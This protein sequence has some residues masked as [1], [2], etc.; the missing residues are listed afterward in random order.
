MINFY[1]IS[2]HILLD[3]LFKGLFWK[4]KCICIISVV[5]IL[6]FRKQVLNKQWQIGTHCYCVVAVYLVA[7]NI[8]SVKMVVLESRITGGEQTSELIHWNPRRWWG[9]WQLKICEITST[10]ICRNRVIYCKFQYGIATYFNLYWFTYW[11][12]ISHDIKLDEM[13]LQWILY[14]EFHLNEHSIN[15]FDSSNS[16][17]HCSEQEH[18][19]TKLDWFEFTLLLLQSNPVKCRTK[20]NFQLFP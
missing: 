17:V 19:K 9:V 2:I 13:F 8:L 3:C 12:I 6:V 16:R 14:C 11:N 5:L 4:W 10:R 18:S 20:Y 1:C 7:F 15:E